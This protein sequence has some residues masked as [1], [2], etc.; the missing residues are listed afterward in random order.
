MRRLRDHGRGD[1]YRHD[2]V[3]VSSR[4][5]GLQAAFL[6]V[7]LRH[8]PEWTQSRRRLAEHYTE[9]LAEVDGATVVPYGAGAVHHLY[10][11]QV[12]AE[13]RAEIRRALSDAGV[14][15][16]VHYPIP[17]SGQPA[18]SHLA[19]PTPNAEAAA[20]QVLSL[21]ID[22]LM[23]TDEVAVVVSSLRDALAS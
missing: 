17:L 11:V 21:P 19:T 23:T 2:E 8:L 14:Q 5:D 1:K 12:D 15:T 6:A 9:A 18:L 16:G 3:G 4:L 22:P 13:K 20:R 10:V 7:K